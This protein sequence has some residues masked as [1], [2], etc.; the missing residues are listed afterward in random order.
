MNL[1]GNRCDRDFVSGASNLVVEWKDGWSSERGAGPTARG[2]KTT[3]FGDERPLAPGAG[4]ACPG[5][6]RWSRPCGEGA[7][8]TRRDEQTIET[9]RARFADSRR[10]TGLFSTVVTLRGGR[11]GS[12]GG[13][14]KVW[15]RGVG[16]FRRGTSRLSAHVV[17]RAKPPLRLHVSDSLTLVRLRGRSRAPD[18]RPRLGAP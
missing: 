4:T 7:A 2:S 11:G 9:N 10:S 14:G 6:S 1:R 3:F 5:R 8:R 16:P 18:Q 17:K 15:G 12:R 13:Y